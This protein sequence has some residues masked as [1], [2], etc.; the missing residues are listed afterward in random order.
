MHT[1]YEKNPRA[2]LFQLDHLQNRYSKHFQTLATN[3]ELEI[4]TPL[5]SMLDMNIG[6][7]Q[8]KH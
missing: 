6:N 3:S 2:H 1:F 7:A 5:Q 4:N 8:I